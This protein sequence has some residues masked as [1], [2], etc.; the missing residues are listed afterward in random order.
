M[1]S[2]RVI[3]G[4]LM[5]R[6][7]CRGPRAAAWLTVAA[8]L[9]TLPSAAVTVA[10]DLP[11]AN[12]VVNADALADAHGGDASWEPLAGGRLTLRST[13]RGGV[14]WATIPA[15]P[16][17]W[18]L[19]RR[20]AVTAEITNI[21]PTEADVSLWV[22]ADRGWEPVG[23][24]APLAPGAG[25]RF[26]CPLRQTFPDGTP[27]LA[28][29]RVTGVRVMLRKSRPGV[30]VRADRFVALGDAGPWQ[31][32]AGRIETP[33]IEDGPPAAGRRVRYRLP[34]AER[35]A[36]H[37]LLALPRDWQPGRT[38]PLI[39]EYPGNIFF[40]PGCFSTG[41]PDQCVIGHGMSQGSGAIWVSLPFIDAAA[42]RIVTDGWG[43]PDDTADYA[44][45]VVEHL[46]D[47]FGADRSKLVLTGFS[48]GAIA[49][50]FIG[51]RNERIASLWKAFHLCQHF[52]GDGWNGSDLAGAVARARR[53]RGAAV[54]HTDNLEQAV[55]PVTE[56]M[57]VPTQFVDSGL[58]AHATAMFLDD[59][60]STRCLRRWFRTL[61][62]AEP[63]HAPE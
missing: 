26:V 58:G 24:H 54:F 60:E 29:D 20:A 49:C 27:K 61:V 12:H 38:Y 32:P 9:A 62:A 18:D 50:G 21:G 10:R 40:V 1:T 7:G 16:G 19:A 48:R 15:A 30:A 23:D 41:L 25:R 4:G 35:Q 53:F 51:L 3:A 52:D 44:L 59:R 47:R 56:A 37:G 45:R 36:I 13:D 5:G 28:P 8:G 11:L 55:R 33:P 31:R 43:D 39:V 6:G 2:E 17:G 57:G 22:L 63:V 14:V 46:S 34:G 42:D